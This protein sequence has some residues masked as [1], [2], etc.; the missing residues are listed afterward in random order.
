[1][2]TKCLL[3]FII[4]FLNCKGEKNLKLKTQK[5]PNI[6]FILVDDL[7]Y[8]DLGVTG[9]AYYETPNVDNLAKESMMFTQG[10]AASRVCSPA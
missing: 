1:M 3:V 10:Y 6:L 8:H 9:S 2:Y 7:G 5:K 4:L